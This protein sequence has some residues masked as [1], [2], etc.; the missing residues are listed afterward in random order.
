MVWT[1]VPEVT[2]YSD[3]GAEPNPGKGGFGVIM[4]YKGIKKEF[5][6]GY[7]LTTNNRMELMGVI[8]GL[9]RLKTKS[10]VNVFTDSQYVINGIEKGWAERWRSKNW[11][12]NNNDMAINYDLWDRLLL[13]IA[14]HEKV[15]FHWVKGHAGHIDNE[16][17]DELAF[18]AL[19]S[20]NLLNDTGYESNMRQTEHGEGSLLSES[21]K[22]VKIKEEGDL[23]RKC[24]AKVIKKQTKK[25]TVKPGQTYYFDYYFLCPGCKTMYMVEDAK[26]EIGSQ[27]DNLFS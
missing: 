3:G 4:S 8:Y 22:N 17:C 23:C 21:F 16:R 2:I 15:K 25:K 13:V 7:A 10:I 9:E 1:E 26:R 14:T 18:S 11:Y 12:R 19:K 24:G 20:D 5:S 6:Q 27:T